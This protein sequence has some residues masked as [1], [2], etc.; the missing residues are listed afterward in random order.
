MRFLEDIFLSVLALRSPFSRVGVALPSVLSSRQYLR[1]VKAALAALF[2]ILTYSGVSAAQTQ[3]TIWP[4]TA[5]P[6]QIDAGADSAVELG[7]TFRAHSSGYITGVRF[8]KSSL[9]TGTHVGNL[10]SCDFR[11]IPGDRE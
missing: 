4:S 9:N 3:Y 1:C 10:W 5:V 6:S 8:Y 2:L 7:V 11:T